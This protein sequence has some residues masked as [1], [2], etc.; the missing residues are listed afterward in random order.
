MSG[1]APIAVTNTDIESLRSTIE[2]IYPT[3]RGRT[4]VDVMMFD[5]LLEV[6]AEYRAQQGSPAGAAGR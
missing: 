5:E 2:A 3:L 1:V 6:L 4:D